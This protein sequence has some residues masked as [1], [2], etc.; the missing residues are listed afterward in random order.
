MTA[1]TA[2]PGAAP[3]PVTQR[4][5]AFCVPSGQQ[6]DGASH[7]PVAARTA[8]PGTWRV[9]AALLMVIGIGWNAGLE[10][11]PFHP[12]MVGISALA[13]HILPLAALMYLLVPALRSGLASAH[14]GRGISIA[15]AAALAFGIFSTIFSATHPHS[16]M[17]IHNVNDALPIAILEA[18][19]LLWLVAGRRA[20][21][22]AR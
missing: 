5:P 13:V 3:Q 10:A 4:T 20:A 17:G 19:A 14:P 15:A 12:A 21:R 18:G 1:K 11:Q 7:G 6:A 8:S 2:G 22:T 16:T 9:V